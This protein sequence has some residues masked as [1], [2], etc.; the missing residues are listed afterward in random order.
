MPSGHTDRVDG[1]SGGIASAGTAELNPDLTGPGGRGPGGVI[2]F[3][4]WGRVSTEDNQDPKSSRGWQGHPRDGADRAAR[5][6]GH[7]RVL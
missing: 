4:F 2:R 6:P 5:G 7:P 1:V 3:A